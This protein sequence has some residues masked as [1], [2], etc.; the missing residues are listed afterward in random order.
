MWYYV[1]EHYNQFISSLVIL[2]PHIFWRHWLEVMQTRSSAIH[3]LFCA[4]ILIIPKLQVIIVKT[5]LFDNC[6]L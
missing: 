3:L 5:D 6:L 1:I 2:C 4:K